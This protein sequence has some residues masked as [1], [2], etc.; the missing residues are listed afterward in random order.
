VS[1]AHSATAIG[2]GAEI[3]AVAASITAWSTWP[4]VAPKVRTAS[5]TAPMSSAKRV[6]IA[7]VTSRAVGLAPDRTRMSAPSPRVTASV[8]PAGTTIAAPARSAF[9]SAV[10]E[11]SSAAV[12]MSAMPEAATLARTWSR[13]TP[14]R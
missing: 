11:A 14:T 4:P 1:A 8:K 6:T 9:I 7:L 12:S 10:A 3:A 5:W 2:L 13:S